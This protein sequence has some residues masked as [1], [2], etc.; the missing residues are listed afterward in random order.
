MND[1]DLLD[2]LLEHDDW[3]TTQLLD[4]CRTLSD[5]QLDQE[6]DIGHRTIRETLAHQIPNYAF[7][8]NLM[9]GQPA[10]DWQGP[11]TLDALI[12][13]HERGYAAF[14]H[15]ARQMRDEGRLEETFRDHHGLPFTFGGTILMVI[16]HNEAHRADVIHIFARLGIPE[17]ANIEVDHGLW[18][19]K[20]RGIV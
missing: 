14:A 2:R 6:F 19:F 15:V 12:A 9:T 17:L 10:M 11:N 13:E 8:T 18:D 5:A 16:L 4:M 1:M 7:W 20:R 3:A